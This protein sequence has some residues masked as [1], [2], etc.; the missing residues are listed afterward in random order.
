[1]TVG[2]VSAVALLDTLAPPDCPVGALQIMTPA[3]PF[4]PNPLAPA[5][6]VG[7]LGGDDADGVAAMLRRVYPTSHSVW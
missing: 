3:G 1:M 4:E 7:P 6:A 2:L 5:L